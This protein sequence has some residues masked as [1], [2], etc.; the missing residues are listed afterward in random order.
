MESRV[1]I[2][3]PECSEPLH[4]LDIY[5]ILQKQGYLIDKYENFALRRVL[6]GDPDTRYI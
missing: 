4:Q 1:N 3:C 5:N 2:S 6:M